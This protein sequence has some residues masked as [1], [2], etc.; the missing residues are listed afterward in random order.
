MSQTFT[1][2]QLHVPH[3]CCGLL[4][5]LL[6]KYDSLAYSVICGLMSSEVTAWRCNPSQTWSSSIPFVLRNVYMQRR[7]HVAPSG[8]IRHCWTVPGHFCSALSQLV[9]G[10][11]WW[12]TFIEFVC[13]CSCA[14][15]AFPPQ[16]REGKALETWRCFGWDTI[17]GTLLFGCNAFCATES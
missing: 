4:I 5:M 1:L 9:P 3:Q 8:S 12:N 10:S 17:C 7:Q 2:S 13:G 11:R 14:G 15:C 6:P 16:T